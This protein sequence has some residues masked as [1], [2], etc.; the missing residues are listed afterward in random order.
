M[1]RICI[2][3][4]EPEEA[5]GRASAV[6]SRRWS[7]S[8][9]SCWSAPSRSQ[10]MSAA[11]RWRSRSCRPR[12][13]PQ[14]SPPARWSARTWS[15]EDLLKPEAEKYLNANFAGATIDA[16]ITEF[17][18]DLSEDEMIVTLEAHASLPTTFMRIFGQNTME[19]AAR[20]EITREM[21]GL[22]VALVL[23]VTGSMIGDGRH[24][25]TKKIDAL[26]T[27]AH[28]SHGDPVRRQ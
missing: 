20:T 5:S 11:A 23:D 12:W 27:A 3:W 26:R 9:P 4:Q 22:E 18:L 28:R 24:D 1:K 19:V 6:R 13:T 7:A 25:A 16:T 15:E 2:I 17:D 14:A 21:T 8:A 10:S